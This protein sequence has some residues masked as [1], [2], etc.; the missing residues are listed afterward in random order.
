MCHAF[1][2]KLVLRKRKGFSAYKWASRGCDVEAWLAYSQNFSNS[3]L[4]PFAGNPAAYL[5]LR[6]LQK[7]LLLFF[8]PTRR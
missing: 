4:E 1:V 7:F 3:F 5:N 2:S 6:G 8:S